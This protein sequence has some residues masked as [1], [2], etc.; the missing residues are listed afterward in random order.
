M[1]SMSLRSKWPWR[2]PNCGASRSHI[3]IALRSTVRVGGQ[4][5]DEYETP[6]GIREAAFDADR[7]FLLN[8]ERV[9]LNGV[10][11]HHEAGSVGSAVPERVWERRFEML[12]EMGCNAIRTSHN[13]VAPELLDLCDRMGFLVMNE[14]FDEWKVGKPQVKGNGYSNYFDEWHERDVTDFVRR[15]RNHPSVV[16]WSCGNEIGDQLSPNGVELLRDLMA[17]FHREDPTRPVT[18]A[19]DQIAAQPKAAPVEFL[20]ALDIVGYN[21]ADR[22]RER[23]E[24]YYSIDKAGAS[25]LAHDRDGKLRH[26]RTARRLS[27]LRARCARSGVGD[28]NRGSVGLAR[29]WPRLPWIGH[30]GALEVRSD[31]RLRGGRLHVDRHRLPGRSRR[32]AEGRL[33]RRARQLRFPQRRLLLLPEPVDREADAAP[34]PALELG[35]SRRPVPAGD[36]LHQLRQRGVVPQRKIGGR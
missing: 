13:P 3:C 20:N 11:L 29:V 26:G 21:Y 19:C 25:Q 15:D 32:R 18:A 23:R 7:G 35:G 12:K 33:F 10:C 24:L 5:V 6:F 34:V 31:P 36:L 2:S 27:R 22:W 28:P 16:L 9:K 30:G 17:I 14:A 4:V 1:A 8:G